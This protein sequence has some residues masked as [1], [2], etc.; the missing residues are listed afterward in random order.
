MLAIVVGASW[1]LVIFCA[2]RVGARSDGAYLP[3]ARQRRQ[4]KRERLNLNPALR[5]QR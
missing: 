3:T 4:W 2:L 1:A 5:R